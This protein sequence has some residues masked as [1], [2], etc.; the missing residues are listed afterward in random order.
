MIIYKNRDFIP[1]MQDVMDCDKGISELNDQWDNIKLLCEINCPIQSKNVLPNM[2][3]I[4]SSFY[5]LQQE[6]ID[7]LV[8]EKLKKMEQKIVFKAQVAIDILIRNLYERTADIGF[9]ATDDDIRNFVKNDNRD[10]YSLNHIRNRLREYVKNYSVY[11]EI[12]ILDQNNQVIA[13]LD[14]SNP[15]LNQTISD[16]IIEETLSTSELYVESFA[17]SALQPL[18]NKSHVFSSRIYDTNS[19]HTIGVICLCFRFEDEMNTIFEKLTADSDGSALLIIDDHNRVIASSDQSHVPI[20]FKVEAVDPGI[21]GIQIHHGISY[22][23][24]TVKSN[25]YQ[26]Y[27]GLGWRGHVMLPLNVACREKTDLGQIDD[28]TAQNLI[29]MAESFSEQLNEIIEKT[30]TI[31]SSLRRIVYNGQIIARDESLHEEYTRLKPLL[32]AIGR[33]GTKTS[34]LF[35]TSVTDLFSTVV[36]SSLSESGFLASLCIDIMDRNLYERAND[37]RWWALDST[38]RRI[39]S[40]ESVSESDKNTLTDI[41]SYINSLYTVYTNLF[42]F[43]KSGTII[44]VSNPKRVGDIGKT[45]NDSYIKNILSNNHS[46]RYFVSPFERT[47]LYDNL[48]T[49]IYGASITDIDHPSQTVGGIG[50]VFDSEFQ[51][52]QILLESVDSEKT[53]AVFTDRHKTIIASTHPNYQTGTTLQLKENFFNVDNGETV[54]ELVSLDSCYAAI[55]CACSSGYREYKT[56]DGYQNDVLAIVID[57][58][59]DCHSGIQSNHKEIEIEQADINYVMNNETIKLATF[60]INDQ[61]FGLDQSVVLE[62]L[63][64]NRIVSMPGV[65][66]PIKGAVEYEGNFIAV[67]NLDILFNNSERNLDTSSLLVLQLSETETVAL[68]VDKL[69]NVLEINLDQIKPVGVSSSITGVFPLGDGSFKTILVMDHQVLLEKLTGHELAED[70]LTNLPLLQKT[71]A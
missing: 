29:S 69:N 48:P 55:G 45:L 21:Q 44:A 35:Q 38:F 11:E 1:H 46:E 58:L 56:S 32:R 53:F 37:C 28:N 15:I 52:K 41:L 14:D 34:N 61:M 27:F 31:N 2:A 50:I 20:G 57:R 17:K 64:T 68:Q 22:I 49:Y 54:S 8:S 16:P 25:G 51:F 42:L 19:Q 47:D 13:N 9:L 26:D 18:R 63:D 59:A 24:K 36:S 12:I 43:D 10:E 66:G 23:T 7:A 6:L 65:S 67:V 62:A 60:V 39:M 70:F 40:K 30:V 3:N 71:D 4:Q 33:I 5:S